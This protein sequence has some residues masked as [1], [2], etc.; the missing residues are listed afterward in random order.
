[1]S[2]EIHMFL[3][4]AQAAAPG[5]YPL[6]ERH[7]ML[8]FVRQAPGSEHDFAAAEAAALKAGWAD[9]DFT[10]AGTLPPEAAAADEPFRSCYAAALADGDAIMVYADAVTRVK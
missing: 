6:G 2:T 8:I 3:A 9:V 10:K 1:M 5:R 4:V 7:P